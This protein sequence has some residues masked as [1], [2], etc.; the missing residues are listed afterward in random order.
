MSYK[1][2]SAPFLVGFMANFLNI[3]K[4]WKFSFGAE[5]AEVARYYLLLQKFFIMEFHKA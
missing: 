3:P 1:I 4:L 5:G 2:K